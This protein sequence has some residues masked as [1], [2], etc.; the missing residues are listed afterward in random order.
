MSK[1]PIKLCVCFYV[2]FLRVQSRVPLRCC[3]CSPHPDGGF[4]AS[5]LASTQDAAAA[6]GLVRS[7]ALSLSLF[8]WWKLWWCVH[9]L[10]TLHNV[11]GAADVFLGL[12]ALNWKEKVPLIARESW[13]LKEMT[14]PPP[15]IP[16][17]LIAARV[18]LLLTVT[19][20]ATPNGSPCCMFRWQEEKKITFEKDSLSCCCVVERR[21]HGLSFWQQFDEAFVTRRTLYWDVSPPPLLAHGKLTADLCEKVKTSPFGLV[22]AESDSGMKQINSF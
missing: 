11:R 20:E 7:V 10:F 1:L 2:V 6:G 14:H 8:Q 9:V 13:R 16:L 17:S 21:C 12:H 15:P 18:S 4:V 3:H 5:F 19:I 22:F